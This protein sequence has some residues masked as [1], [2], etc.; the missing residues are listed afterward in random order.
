MNRV[1][2]LLSGG[3]DSVA[4]LVVLVDK[5]GNPEYKD[6]EIVP[7]FIRRR[8]RTICREQAA[9]QQVCN[10]LGLKL[11]ILDA[12]GYSFG[13]HGDKQSTVILEY[14]AP[15]QA[16]LH[17]CDCVVYSGES[18]CT[19][20]TFEECLE[21]DNFDLQ[22]GE[23]DHIEALWKTAGVELEDLTPVDERRMLVLPTHIPSFD[24][25]GI[26]PVTDSYS[27]WSIQK[28]NEECGTCWKC[29]RKYLTCRA[30]FSRQEL[31]ESH[32]WKKDPMSS[33]KNI[34]LL[35][36]LYEDILAHP[37]GFVSVDFEQNSLDDLEDMQRIIEADTQE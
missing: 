16:V 9:A 25:L 23:T 13:D 29:L 1:L 32:R 37:G 19:R 20:P 22:H 10:K 2:V 24:R 7:L 17:G 33:S 18:S 4:S 27:C 5:I 35:R 3:F 30:S 12:R 36:R 26:S 8:G 31:L 15:F 34:K 21:R 6:Y 14:I 11:Q 28:P